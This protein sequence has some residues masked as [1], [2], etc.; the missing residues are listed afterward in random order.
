MPQSKYKVRN[1]GQ[2]NTGVIGALLARGLKPV[3]AA[4]CGAFLHGLSVE[5]GGGPIVAGDIVNGLPSAFE[6][7][8]TYESP[9]VRVGP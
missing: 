4:I 8:S 6:R 3:D 1:N 5:G 2:I 7:L 9:F